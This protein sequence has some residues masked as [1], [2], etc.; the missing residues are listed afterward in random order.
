VPLA[1]R[2][3]RRR[4]VAVAA[5]LVALIALIGVT[6]WLAR[7]EPFARPATAQ[8]P[9][10][11]DIVKQRSELG[12]STQP[13][14][15][16]ASLGTCLNVPII[17]YHYIRLD[18]N[19]K[20][21]VGRSLS[22]APAVFQE[23]MDWLRA[24]GAHTVTLAQVMQAFAGGP[25][26]P[27][28]PVV[29]TFDDGYADFA[30]TAAPV[31]LRD[32]FVGTDFVVPGFLGHPSY[33]TAAQV[34][35]VAAE[36]MV[37]GAHTMHHVDLVALPLQL[38]NLEISA[39]KRVLESLLRQRVLDFAYPFGDVDSAV[40]SLVQQ[41]GFRDAVTTSSGSQQCSSQAY[42]LHR[43]RVGSSLWLLSRAVGIPA[44]PASWI[45]RSPPPV[46]PSNV[47]AHQVNVSS[48]DRLR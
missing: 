29:L 27:S 36:G 35:Q 37:I 6:A 5:G 43:I 30:T 18:T 46:Q 14:A 9:N 8:L 15:R 23:Q 48:Q 20:D 34:Q 47:L 21:P 12:P 41:A 38:A 7:P 19:P 31:L 33:M 3:R 10:G 2:R 28:H 42:Q 16:A 44:P 13:R 22:V 45:D 24:E 32:G 40:V 39:S 26:L 17:L 4:P 11:P 25:A 1:F